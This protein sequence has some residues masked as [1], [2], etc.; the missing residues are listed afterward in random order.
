M[1]VLG[2]DVR[3]IIQVGGSAAITLPKEYLQAY[4][5]KLGDK[6]ELIFDSCIRIEPVRPEE[7]RRKL[8]LETEVEK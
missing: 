3:K 7:I 5:L 1:E 2:K 6:V 8:G 4:G